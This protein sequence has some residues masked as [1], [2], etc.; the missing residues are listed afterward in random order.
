MVSVTRSLVS[1]I[2]EISVSFNFFHEKVFLAAC[3]FLLLNSLFFQFTKPHLNPNGTC[4]YSFGVFSFD[5]IMNRHL[6]LKPER[7]F[8]TSQRSSDVISFITIINTHTHSW[9]SLMTLYFYSLLWHRSI[10]QF[11]RLSKHS[12]INGQGARKGGVPGANGEP[13]ISVI[14]HPPSSIFSHCYF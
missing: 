6:K 14:S 7:S 1:L 8:H 5:S 2:S 11:T 10:L 4:L 12:N 9:M 3:L 13:G